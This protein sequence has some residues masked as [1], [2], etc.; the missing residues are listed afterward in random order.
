VAG[1]PLLLPLLLPFVL[2]KGSSQL[3][4]ASA[5]ALAAEALRTRQMM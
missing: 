4:F 2:Q 5:A 1:V 3:C